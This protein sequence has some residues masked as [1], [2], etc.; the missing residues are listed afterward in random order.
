MLTCSRLFFP[1][2]S[3]WQP[4]LCNTDITEGGTR[5]TKGWTRFN[6]EDLVKWIWF[7]G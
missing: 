1:Q 2:S 6:R 3:V 4:A 7:Y 5:I